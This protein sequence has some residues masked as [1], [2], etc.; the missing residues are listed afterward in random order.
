MLEY[1]TEPAVVIVPFDSP[2]FWLQQILYFSV[3]FI[4]IAAC[5]GYFSRKNLVEA[6]RKS[7]LLS[8][9]I[10]LPPFIN[11]LLVKIGIIS[12]ICSGYVGET[13]VGLIKSFLTL[14]IFRTTNCG[15]STGITI[16]LVVLAALLFK[17]L[18][19]FTTTFR[20]LIG[21][22]IATVVGFTQ[23]ALPGIIGS[24]S[25]IVHQGIGAQDWLVNTVFQNS[26]LSSIHFFAF[27]NALPQ[28]VQQVSTLK[29]VI[30]Q[31]SL[32]FTRWHYITLVVA[33]FILLKISAPKLFYSIKNSFQYSRIFLYGTLILFGTRMA[34]NPSLGRMISN[35][36]DFV[37][38]LIL[39]L[40][41]FCIA[42]AV[43]VVNDDNDQLIDE[44]SNETRPLPS[45]VSLATYRTFGIAMA[46]FGITGA[47]LI[48]PSVFWIMVLGGGVVLV[49]SAPPLRLRTTIIGTWISALLGAL[50]AL[51]S[52]YFLVSLDQSLSNIP[53]V[54]M[55]VVS[56]LFGVIIL[57]K[58]FKDIK[59]D[60]QNGIQTLPIAA[61]EKNAKIV[62][63]IVSSVGMI[64]ISIFYYNVLTTVFTAIV[65]A[66]ASRNYFKHTYSDKRI[67]AY[68][69]IWLVVVM[70]FW[71]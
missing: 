15:V 35:N 13:G 27:D 4:T 56:A 40:S 2:L 44:V 58:D 30:A 25:G 53:I 18:C 24:F 20:A 47:A 61:G 71:K 60:S 59:G 68:F 45:G 19:S 62:L 29:G 46:L 42:L 12:N 9:V 17:T 70:L 39:F 52:G 37:S 7:V 64:L 5:I 54:P 6:W 3:I 55:V 22:F 14:G 26:L 34:A 67:F 51:L 63:G 57:Y 21:T 16:G 23:G 28:A 50:C 33:V 43:T 11:A 8:W 69:V 36:A 49:Y 38:L 32:Y 48:S 1:A 10:L 41:F 31:W 65:I 66:V